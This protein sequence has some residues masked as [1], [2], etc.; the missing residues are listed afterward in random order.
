MIVELTSGEKVKL[1][2]S[3]AQ[4]LLRVVATEESCGKPLSL[5]FESNC[6]SPKRETVTAEA[7]VRK[8][9][10]VRTKKRKPQT[11][12]EGRVFSFSDYLATPEGFWCGDELRA[13]FRLLIAQGRHKP[14]VLHC[15]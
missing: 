12:L 1:T 13:K 3:Q 4:L 10:L 9:L 11:T 6:S 14:L 8:G 7:L 2:D 15:D 5:I